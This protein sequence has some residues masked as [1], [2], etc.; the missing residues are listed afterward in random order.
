MLWIANSK[1]AFVGKFFFESEGKSGKILVLPSGNFTPAHYNNSQCLALA[2]P[3]R[4]KRPF[5]P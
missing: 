3:T 5:T 4:R 1:V 2:E